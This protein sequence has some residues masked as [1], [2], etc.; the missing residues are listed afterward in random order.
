[1]FIYTGCLRHRIRPYQLHN[2]SLTSTHKASVVFWQKILIVGIILL[3]KI[4]RQE[5]HLEETAV[6]GSSGQEAWEKLSI[7]S[8]IIPASE[9]R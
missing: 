7:S 8:L 6:T 3:S 1:M 4:T 2:I 9:L 5:I